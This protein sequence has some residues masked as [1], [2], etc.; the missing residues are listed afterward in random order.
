[1]ITKRKK[2]VDPSPLPMRICLCGCKN[3]FQPNRSNHFN[4]NYKHTNFAYNHGTRKEKYAEE[5]EVTKRI[6]KNDRIL[7][8]YFKKSDK[9]IVKLNF[10]I[11]KADGFDEGI[12][13]QIVGVIQDEIE[14]KYNAVYKFCFRLIKQG[15]INFIEIREL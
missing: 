2:N 1:M 5:I 4:V 12:F 13:T 15:E 8:K 11:I 10:T 9:Q 7:E 14:R 3:E 6:R